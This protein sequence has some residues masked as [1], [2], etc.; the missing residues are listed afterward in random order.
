[1]PREDRPTVYSTDPNFARRCPRCNHD[2][3]RCSQVRSLPPQQQVAAIHFEKNGRGGKT[4]SIIRGLQLAPDD[5]KALARELKAACGTGGTV[6][7][8]A[9]EIQ[10]DQREKIA[11]RLKAL[12]YK[13]KFVGG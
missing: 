10:G 8:G 1:M 5:L 11:A 4:V 6:K 2:P 3:C 13:T 12:G 9:I 7:D